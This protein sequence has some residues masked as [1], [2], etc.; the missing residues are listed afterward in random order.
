MDQNERQVIEGL[1]QRLGQSQNQQRD[2]E[3]ERLISERIAQYPYAPYTMAQTILVQEHALTNLNEQM[4]Q[5]QAEIQHLRANQQSSGGFLSGLFGGGRQQAAPQ[6]P[7]RAYSPAQQNQ[8][9]MGQ[10]ANPSPFNNMQPAPAP[11][12]GPWGQR[13]ASPQAPAAGGGFLQGALMTAAGVAGGMVAGN[14]LMNAF[15]GSK[16]NASEAASTPQH[17]ADNSQDDGQNESSNDYSAYEEPE[18]NYAQDYSDAGDGGG[19]WA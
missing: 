2:P 14:M 12:A 4:Q 13:Q 8:G 10:P 19:D 16:A 6:A 7:V 15:S 9:G 1:F 3:A 17:L 11:A 18:Q 5:M